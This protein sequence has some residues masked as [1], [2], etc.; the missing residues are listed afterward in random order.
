MDDDE[1]TRTGPR[2][3]TGAY[4][5]VYGRLPPPVQLVGLQLWLPVAFIVLFCFCYIAAFH[6]PK[7]HQ[8]PAAVAAPAPAVA[9]LQQ[10]TGTA[11]DYRTV[12][13]AAAA[14]AE[15]RDGSVIGAL[16]DPAGAHPTLYVAS[17]HQ[18]QTATIA[19]SLFTPVF[20]AQGKQ[21]TVRDLAPLPPWDSFGMTTMY[22]MLAWCIGGYMVSMFIGMMGAPLL[23]RTRVGIIVGGAVVLSLVSNLLAGPVIGAFHGHFW[24]LTGI[25]IGWIITI[26]LTVNGLSYFA[27]RFITL[28]AILLFVFL[29]V[30][31]SGAAYPTWMLPSFFGDLQHYVVGYG[32]TEMIKRTLYGVGQ[33]YAFG[34]LQILCYAAAGVVL[35]AI[36]KPFRQ[37]REVRRILAQ[38]TTMMADAQNANREQGLK[39]RE[40]V[41]A[42]YGV[43]DAESSEDAE[44]VLA[45][46][47]LAGDAFSN[48][49]RPLSGLESGPGRDEQRTHAEGR[50]APPER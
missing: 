11:V 32:M 17:A 19:E 26:G 28:P 39:L 48:Y 49:G 31:S 14:Q 43:P 37:R 22:L 2:R 12:A 38:R 15:V 30:P 23:H 7:I 21:L 25:A 10:A 29:S 46:E 9:A 44:D 33:P 50:S 4:R 36:G 42:H 45:G 27:G 35:M 5:R 20:A 1:A 16:V 40:G 6:A 3:L 47:E 24:Q 8:A 34:L 41:L 13:D 18:Y